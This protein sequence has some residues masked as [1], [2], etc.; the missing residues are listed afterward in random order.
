MTGSV[1]YAL[2]QPSAYNTLQNLLRRHMIVCGLS[3]FLL[4]IT[5]SIR[6]KVSGK[7]DLNGLGSH[8]YYTGSR[9]GNI[10]HGAQILNCIETLATIK[11]TTPYNETEYLLKFSTRTVTI[12]KF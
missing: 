7:F 12:T 5:L 9:E 10:S 6:H 2:F 11:V 4:R 1:K 8:I 3:P